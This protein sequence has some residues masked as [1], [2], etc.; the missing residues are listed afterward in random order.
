MIRLRSL[1]SIHPLTHQGQLPGLQNLM[2]VPSRR[3]AIPAGI[4]AQAT[5]HQ[6][7]AAGIRIIHNNNLHKSNGKMLVFEELVK[8]IAQMTF[9]NT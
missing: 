5:L 6:Y 3:Q 8:N 7:V 4:I 9:K 2:P 1:R